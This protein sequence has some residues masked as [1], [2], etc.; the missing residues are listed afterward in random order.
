MVFASSEIQTLID[1]GIKFLAKIQKKETHNTEYFKGEFTSTMTMDHSFPFL[2]WRGKF[3][4][5]SNNFTTASVYLALA[6]IYES[7]PQSYREIPPLLNLAHEN[8]KLFRDGDGFGFWQFIPVR[9]HVPHRLPNHPLVQ[10]PNFKVRRSNNFFLKTLAFN[11]V[12]N[13][14]NDS[15]D[16]ALGYIGISYQKKFHEA[17]PEI[18][19]APM[20]IPSSI[21]SLFS[22][23]VDVDRIK[24]NPFNR[25]YGTRRL[26]GPTGSFLTWFRD[27]RPGVR[28]TL[29]KIGDSYVPFG[30]N[31]IDCVVNANILSA[32]ARYDQLESGGGTKGACSFLNQV[33]KNKTYATCGMYYPNWYNYFHNAT[34][35]L[36]NGAL[37]LEENLDMLINDLL[38]DQFE[39]GQW[40]SY[41]NGEDFDEIQ[42]TAYAFSAL[43]NIKLSHQKY[44]LQISTKLMEKI[45]QALDKSYRW[46]VKEA[47]RHD[48]KSVSWSGGIFFSGGTVVRK[49]VT[50]RSD[51]YTTALIIRSLNYY[52]KF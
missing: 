44:H 31:D 49:A 20:E 26:K 28:D 25:I 11:F 7:N 21:G 27:E 17:E 52:K 10:D 4:P 47:T 12:E 43:V 46:L 36:N 41:F 2:G 50:W 29:P 23:Y 24:F 33:V 19:N 45:N 30:L 9:E 38:E 37:C 16:T 40:H 39:D 35:A 3:A 13:I 14:P 15:D 5:D 18:F 32:L 22:R 1:G 34:M 8:M 6:Q 51:A 42:A 48:D